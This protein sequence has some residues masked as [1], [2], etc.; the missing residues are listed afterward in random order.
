MWL[1]WACEVKGSTASAA[2]GAGHLLVQ[3]Q[4]SANPLS[5]WNGNTCPH[6]PYSRYSGCT[7]VHVAVLL[8]AVQADAALLLVDGSPGGFE[9]GFR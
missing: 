7:S 1:T 2:V 6:L 8:Y 3:L 5:W 4:G 9:A